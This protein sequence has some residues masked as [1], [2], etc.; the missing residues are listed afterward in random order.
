MLCA[1][2]GAYVVYWGDAHY[3]RRVSAVQVRGGEWLLPAE[4]MDC[5]ISLFPPSFFLPSFPTGR[6]DGPVLF[7][8]PRLLPEGV[9]A[10]GPRQ[11]GR[12]E[13]D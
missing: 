10:A 8:V 2:H 13:I 3:P 7:L 12:L 11:E 4:L 6:G 1:V 9:P 5:H